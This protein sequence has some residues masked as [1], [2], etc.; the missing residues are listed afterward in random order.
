MWA[1]SGAGF[2]LSSNTS[3]RSSFFVLEVKVGPETRRGEESRAPEVT[4]VRG[5]DERCVVLEVGS[6]REAVTDP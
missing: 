2:D 4:N 5:S 3:A 1:V 6:Y